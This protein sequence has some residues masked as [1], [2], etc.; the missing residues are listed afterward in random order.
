M[1]DSKYCSHCGALLTE[2]SAYC[3][4]CGRA[5]AAG[6]AAYAAGQAVP[7]KKRSEKD[8]KDEKGE[9]EEKGEKDEK[10]GKDNWI[11]SLFGGLI[12]IWLGIVF[13]IAVSQPSVGWNNW[14]NY[15]LAGL[16]IILVLEGALLGSRR[17]SFAPFYGLIVGG[18]IVALIGIGPLFW[19]YSVWPYIVIVLGIFVILVAIFGRRRT[20]RP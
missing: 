11:T 17:G 8:E 20:P 1:S 5:V 12:L 15:F 3:S 14:W 19:T 16:G 18:V 10:G 13:A 4:R 7:P 6:A 9:K 2:G